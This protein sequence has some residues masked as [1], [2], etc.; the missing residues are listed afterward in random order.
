[1]KFLNSFVCSYSDNVSVFLISFQLRKKTMPGLLE[2]GGIVN[3]PNNQ[4][5]L[6]HFAEVGEKLGEKG[7]AETILRVLLC[8]FPNLVYIF[9]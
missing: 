6:H 2:V 5:R 3:I 8:D 7:Q 1:M 9:M 4:R